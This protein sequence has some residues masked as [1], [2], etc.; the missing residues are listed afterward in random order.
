MSK[1]FRAANTADRTPP[2]YGKKDLFVCFAFFAPLRESFR[3]RSRPGSRTLILTLLLAGAVLAGCR[4]HS[5]PRLKTFPRTVLW[6]WERPEDLRFIDPHQVGVAFLA[7]TLFLRGAQVTVRPRLQPL[8]VPDGTALMAVVRV[9]SDRT[10]PPALSPDLGSKAASA[11]QEAAALPAVAAV[12][13]DFDATASERAFYRQLL[14]DL[15][16]RL[17]ASVPISI[18][19]LASWCLH[20]S[21]LS[22]LPVDEAVP[23]LFRMGAESHK[24]LLDLEAGKDFRFAVCRDSIGISTDEDLPRLPSGRRVYIFHP[25]SWSEDAW[26]RIITRVRQ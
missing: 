15:R 13:V 22:E 19:A 24:V 18:T 9:E 14:K 5:S 12:Q 8:L 7:K 11:I 3:S 20:D 21:W 23:M 25:R 4:N 1:S 26:R 2:P 10:E 6:A 17:P 16:A